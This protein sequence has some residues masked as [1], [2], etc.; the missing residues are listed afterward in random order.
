LNIAIMRA[1]SAGGGGSQFHLY[2]WAPDPQIFEPYYGIEQINWNGY[3]RP[4]PMRHGTPHPPNE[5]PLPDYA[6]VDADIKQGIGVL[7]GGR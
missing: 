3:T 2:V 7:D 1:G 5:P 6:L 4:A